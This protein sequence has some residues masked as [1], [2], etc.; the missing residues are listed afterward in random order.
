MNKQTIIMSALLTV[1]L[2]SLGIGMHNTEG[3]TDMKSNYAIAQKTAAGIVDPSDNTVKYNSDNFNVTYHE[4]IEKILSQNDVL[5]IDSGNAY[6]IDKS[7]NKVKL[8]PVGMGVSPTY[9]VPGSY[10]FGA[11]TYVPNYEDSVY[12]SKTTGESSATPLQTATVAGGFCQ[13]NKDYPE[14]L[15][16][17]CMKTDVNACASTSCC[18]L[19]GGSKCVSGNEQGPKKREN[20]GDTR[21]LNRDYYYYKG[22]CYGNCSGASFNYS[23]LKPNTINGLET[24]Y[25]DA[26]G[27]LLKK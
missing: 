1:I 11:S 18:V 4:S 2:L 5:G 10:K 7:G 13:A 3:Y 24:A 22:K 17:E 16:E 15:E 20:Y 9:Y 8:P 19:L 21:I 25:K 27:T 14:K 23:P 26:S 6:V 12:L